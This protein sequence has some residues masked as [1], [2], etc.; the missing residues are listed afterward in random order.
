[1]SGILNLYSKTKIKSVGQKEV[2]LQKPQENAVK[3]SLPPWNSQSRW[4][5]L[6]QAL[7]KNFMYQTASFS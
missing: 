5:Q 2:L 6:K 3:F 4:H 7:I 1:M